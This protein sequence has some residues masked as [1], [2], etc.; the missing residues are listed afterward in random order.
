MRTYRNASATTCPNGSRRRLYGKVP[1]GGLEA[2]RNRQCFRRRQSPISTGG[3]PRDVTETARANF[4]RR[5]CQRPVR[6]GVTPLRRRPS[7]QPLPLQIRHRHQHLLRDRSFCASSFVINTDPTSLP[8]SFQI[9]LHDPIYIH[10]LSGFRYHSTSCFAVNIPW[11]PNS[12]S[13]LLCRA[14]PPSS[15]ANHATH[16]HPNCISST[17]CFMI[18]SSPATLT[19][20]CPLICLRV[21]P[22][23]FGT[24]P[25]DHSSQVPPSFESCFTFRRGAYARPRPPSRGLPRGTSWTPRNGFLTDSQGVRQEWT[26]RGITTQMHGTWG[27]AASK[28]VKGRPSGQLSGP[29]AWP[30][31]APRKSPNTCIQGLWRSLFREDAAFGTPTDTADTCGQEKAKWGGRDSR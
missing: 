20:L 12:L 19:A 24:H 4:L 17:P 28:H 26:K 27:S 6:E 11:H 29:N 9:L 25:R 16:Q 7:S 18:F 13:T 8:L 3:T 14:V 1:G 22:L 31:H 5:G 15:F 10:I 30:K 21:P 2:R 23:P